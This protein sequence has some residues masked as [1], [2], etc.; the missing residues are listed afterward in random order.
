MSTITPHIDHHI[1]LKLAAELHRQFDHLSNRL[2]VFAVHVKD[3]NLQHFGDVGAIGRASPFV[4]QRRESDLVIDNNVQ[5][6]ANLIAVQLAEVQRFLDDPFTS[7][8]C[9]AVDQH[10][11][12]LFVIT[13][14]ETI[15]LTAA[16]SHR[17]RV[18]EFKVARVKAK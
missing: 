12:A 9:V 5:C 15:L 6:P 8:G 14:F 13:I 4:G 17:N 1:T 3:R 2:G 7:K 11:H 16:A 18:H 10:G